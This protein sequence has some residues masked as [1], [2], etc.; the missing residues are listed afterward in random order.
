MAG[1]VLTRSVRKH[2]TEGVSRP[3]LS[4][5]WGELVRVEPD[6]TVPRQWSWMRRAGCARARLDS[7]LVAPGQADHAF[8][9]TASSPTVFP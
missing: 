3:S 4:G 7:G 8:C 1:G 2:A 6:D 9:V 5:V